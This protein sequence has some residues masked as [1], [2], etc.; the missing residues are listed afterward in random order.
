M[1]LGN[2]SE[3]TERIGA[4]LSPATPN[5]GFSV[6]RDCIKLT[7]MHWPREMC[8]RSVIPRGEFAQNAISR[9]DLLKTK[10]LWYEGT[11]LSRHVLKD[12]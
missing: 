12:Q 1:K 10:G 3:D 6:A 11:M 2:L 5:T 8:H 4:I 7:V 9:R